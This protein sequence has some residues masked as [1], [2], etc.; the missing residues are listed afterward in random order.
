MK[1]KLIITIK[2]GFLLSLALKVRVLGTQKWPINLD[3]VFCTW[4]KVNEKNKS[5]SARNLK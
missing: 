5:R 4:A 1:M 2:K 3:L